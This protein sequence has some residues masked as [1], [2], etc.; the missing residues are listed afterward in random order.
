MKE[1]AVVILAAGKG[2]RMG[3]GYP[4]VLFQVKGKP[5]IYY[6]LETVYALAPERLIVVVGF[7][8]D[9]VKQYL[10]RFHG[11]EFAYQDKLLGTGDAVL[12]TKEIL[13]EF[14]GDI[15]VLCGDVPFIREKTIRELVRFHRE[16]GASATVLSAVLPDAKE[17]GRIIKS[18]SGELERIVEFKDATE[19]ERAV[20]EINSGVII[21]KKED[22]FA[23]IDDVDTRNAQ[24]EKYLTDMIGIL[25]AAGRRT[26]VYPASEPMEVLG[27]NSPEQLAMAENYLS[28]RSCKK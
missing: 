7:M 6:L 22:L 24:G 14:N 25:K 9:K 3:G 2:K 27:I 8:H 28:E 1:L 4:K 18:P 20:R 17:Y 11:I 21:F 12:R 16:N 10:S 5:I 23:H 13:S 15:L 26:F 19:D